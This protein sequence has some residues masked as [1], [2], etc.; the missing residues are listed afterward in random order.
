MMGRP[1]AIVS[2]LDAFMQRAD[3][4]PISRSPAMLS[5]PDVPSQP[6]SH[7]LHGS[8]GLRINEQPVAFDQSVAEAALTHPNSLH[9]RHDSLLSRYDSGLTGSGIGLELEGG[10]IPRQAPQPTQ[11]EGPDESRQAMDAMR[12]SLLLQGKVMGHNRTASAPSMPNQPG[13]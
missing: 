6:P 13:T 10:Y 5:T 2:G 1:H 7:A 12:N 11:H 3:R 4:T 8:Y 9:T